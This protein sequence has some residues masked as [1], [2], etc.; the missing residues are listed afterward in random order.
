MLTIKNHGIVSGIGIFL[1]RLLREN[2]PNW[3]GIQTI[4][5][6]INSWNKYI[7]AVVIVLV[8]FTIIF[9]CLDP[10]VALNSNTFKLQGLYGIDIPLIKIT[11]VDVITLNEMPTISIRTKGLLTIAIKCIIST[12][13]VQRKRN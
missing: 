13:K 9:L 5:T 12:E 11:G 7:Y 6:P 2:C 4:K 8:V 3:I 10:K 1:S